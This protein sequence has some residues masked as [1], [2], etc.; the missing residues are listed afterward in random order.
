MSFEP[1][2]IERRLM[3]QRVLGESL[4]LLFA[5]LGTLFVLALAPALLMEAALLLATSA[6]PDPQ[7][8]GTLPAGLIWVAI[9]SSLAGQVVVALVTLA[10]VDCA[11]GWRRSLGAYVA[12]ALRNLGPILVVG[13]VLSLA[14]GLATM[15]FVLPGIYVF[16][17]FFVWLPCILFERQGLGALGRSQAL[18]RGHRWPLVGAI[19][20]LVLIFVG[21]LVLVGPI[22]TSLAANTGGIIAALLSACLSALSYAVIGVFCAL[23]YLRLRFLEDGTTPEQVAA[24]V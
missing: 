4:R 2:G 19:G 16:A 12:I 8:A 6:S 9:L 17:V 14:A 21:L 23:V 13:T 7:E 5:N 15:V 1:G 3:A 10:A 18:T 22:W 11:A 24:S 20:A